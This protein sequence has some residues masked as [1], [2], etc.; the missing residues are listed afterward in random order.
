MQEG[1]FSGNDFEA[2][3]KPPLLLL[4]VVMFLLAYAGGFYFTYRKK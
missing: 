2:L 4:A 1:A 3:Q